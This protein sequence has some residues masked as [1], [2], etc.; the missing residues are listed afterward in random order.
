MAVAACNWNG[1]FVNGELM[2]VV[3]GGKVDSCGHGAEF[4]DAHQ[5]VFQGNWGRMFRVELARNGA[6]LDVQ[7]F[8]IVPDDDVWFG[9]D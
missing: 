2:Y 5:I 3:T 7:R 8:R 9:R 6:V 1:S 4:V